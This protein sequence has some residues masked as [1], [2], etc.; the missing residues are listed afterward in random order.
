L[1]NITVHTTGVNWA[2]YTPANLRTPTSIE[3]CNTA[4]NFQSSEYIAQSPT[5]L[6]NSEISSEN[7]LNSKALNIDNIK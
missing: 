4:I 1:D 6:K 7:E 2:D 3:L 5:M